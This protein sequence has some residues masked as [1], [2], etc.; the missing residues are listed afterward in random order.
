MKYPET[1]DLPPKQGKA[2]ARA[3]KRSEILEKL[4]Q[5]TKEGRCEY[6]PC[7]F[8]CYVIDDDDDGKGREKKDSSKDKLTPTGSSTAEN[9]AG[10]AVPQEDLEALPL[11][12]FHGSRIEFA[13]FILIGHPGFSERRSLEK[14]S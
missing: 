11:A 4:E 2:N 8:R 10:L 5:H 6:P 3:S 1:N 13:H 14:V 7:C 12:H 9:L